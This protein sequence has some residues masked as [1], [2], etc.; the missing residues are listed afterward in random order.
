[1]SGHSKW[2]KI[3]HQKAA[4]DP[5]KGK[6]FTQH[7]KAIILAARQGGPDP[8]MNASLR[9]AIDDAKADNLPK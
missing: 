7:A 8:D 2:H 1:M 3:K 6:L 9:K 4:N 5:K